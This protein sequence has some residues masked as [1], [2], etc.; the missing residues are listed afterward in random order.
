MQSAKNTSSFLDQVEIHHGPAP[1]LGRYVLYADSTTRK[2]G[3]QLSIEPISLLTEINEKNRDS[4]TPLMPGLDVKH[5]DLDNTNSICIVGRNSDGEIVA[6][7]AARLY[8]LSNTTLKDAAENLSIYYRNPSSHASAGENCRMH[9]WMGT[10][11]RGQAGYSGA[12]WVRP[13]N[14]GKRLVQILPRLARTL[15]TGKWGPD[16]VFGLMEQKLVL[17]GVL[18][19]NGFRNHEWSMEFS[20][21]AIGTYKFALLWEKPSDVGEGVEEFLSAAS[22]DI[23]DIQPTRRA[24]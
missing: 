17:G 7:Q 3:V 9:A 24:Q 19:L 12:T 5:S 6:T 11:L 23:R 21:P 18:G 10:M 8:D 13:D 2:N 16:F 20:S 22:G 4:W 1:L 14:R 15:A